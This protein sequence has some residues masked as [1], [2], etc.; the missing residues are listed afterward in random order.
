MVGINLQSNIQIIEFFCPRT[1]LD[2]P[3][4]LGKNKL[5]KRKK[6]LWGLR[7]SSMNDNELEDN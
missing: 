6:E 3:E 2:L 4:N 7:D 1:L 5:K